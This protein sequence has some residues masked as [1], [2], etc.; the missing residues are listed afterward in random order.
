[1]TDVAARPGV[2]EAALNLRRNQDGG[3]ESGELKRLRELEHAKRRLRTIAALKKLDVVVK[4]MGRQDGAPIV[5]WR[6]RM[7]QG[8]RQT[9]VASERPI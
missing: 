8:L 6:G 3:L 1:M 9:F 4:R 7:V 5:H 2:T